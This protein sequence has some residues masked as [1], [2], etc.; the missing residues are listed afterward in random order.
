RPRP[1]GPA[2]A[3]PRPRPGLGQVNKNRAVLK[4]KSR[5]AQGLPTRRSLEK[6]PVVDRTFATRGFTWENDKCRHNLV[7][8]KQLLFTPVGARI[9]QPVPLRCQSIK[10]RL[11][12]SATP[13]TRQISLR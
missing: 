12:N 6:P 13:N 9:P 3:S 10:R 2:A 8:P 5:I 11:T 4:G 7:M 1:T